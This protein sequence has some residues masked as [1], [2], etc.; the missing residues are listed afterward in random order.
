VFISL[1]GVI[2]EELIKFAKANKLEGGLSYELSMHGS[3]GALDEFYKIFSDDLELAYPVSKIDGI[4]VKPNE[5][6]IH[7]IS[8][9]NKEPNHHDRESIIDFIHDAV[10]TSLWHGSW[11]TS[12]GRS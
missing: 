1:D 7:I 11:R 4:Y 6:V 5:V 8:F 2:M 12:I 3:K 9:K 10:Q